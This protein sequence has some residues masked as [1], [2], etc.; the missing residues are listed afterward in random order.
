MRSSLK[1]Y[2]AG[3][4]DKHVAYGQRERK[5]RLI[6]RGILPGFKVV[7][8]SEKDAENLARSLRLRAERISETEDLRCGVK[9]R[10]EGKKVYAIRTK[11]HLD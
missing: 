4:F 8:R 3:T 1:E 7:A 9:V 10:V 2:R 6:A 5:I 11:K